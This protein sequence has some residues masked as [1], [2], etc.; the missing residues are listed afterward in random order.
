VL[1]RCWRALS[2]RE[3]SCRSRYDY[4]TYYHDCDCFRTRTKS[5]HTT[6][7]RLL[8]A[9]AD[10]DKLNV[11]DDGATTAA[12]SIVVPTEERSCTVLTDAVRSSR[13]QFV[14]SRKGTQHITTQCPCSLS[15]KWLQAPTNRHHA[16]LSFLS[17]RIKVP[18]RVKQ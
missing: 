1:P 9:T 8:W 10:F 11:C 5:R 14:K 3:E 12:P 16:A 6:S 18:Q 7:I 15:S 13:H 4:S 17:I 2:L